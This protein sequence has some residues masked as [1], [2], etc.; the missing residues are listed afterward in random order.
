VALLVSTLPSLVVGV[1]VER[2]DSRCQLCQIATIDVGS[3]Y[4]NAPMEGERVLMK[5]NRSLSS[6][7]VELYPVFSIRASYL[8][9][10]RGKTSQST[11]WLH[12][13]CKF[14]NK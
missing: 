13:K 14:R 1:C 4:L 5:L 6:M 9:H 3:A 12:P 7:M 8:W 10:H 2:M 11:I